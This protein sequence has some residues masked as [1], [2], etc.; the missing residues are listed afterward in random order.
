LANVSSPPLLSHHA[1]TCRQGKLHAALQ[2]LQKALKIESR[3]E[4]VQNPADTHLNCCAVLSQLGRH[5]SALEHAQSALILLQVSQ[6]ATPVANTDDRSCVSR[7]LQEELF[8]GLNPLNDQGAA[9]MPKADRI[10]VLA[11]AYHNIAVEQEF[12]KKVRAGRT[13]I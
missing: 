8:R 9:Q 12:L 2:Y 10:A 1:K 11:I 6:S 3:I 4:R 7:G 5:Q 13:A